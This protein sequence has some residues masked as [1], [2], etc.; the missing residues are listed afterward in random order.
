[1]YLKIKVITDSKAEK[2]EKTEEDSWK[3]WVKA[4]AKN[5]LA[6]KRILEIIRGN[7]PNKLVKIISGHHSPAKIVSIS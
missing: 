3:I 1:M 6:N 5:N 7:Y 4:P 2:L